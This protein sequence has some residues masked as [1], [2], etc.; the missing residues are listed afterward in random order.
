MRGYNF[1]VVQCLIP[2]RQSPSSSA[3]GQRVHSRLKLHGACE[4]L[5]CCG[6]QLLLAASRT[7]Q[8][9]DANGTQC[10]QTQTQH[11]LPPPPLKT[12]KKGVSEGAGLAPQRPKKQLSCRESCA[13]CHLDCQGTTSR[14]EPEQDTPTP[15][16]PGKAAQ[17]VRRGDARREARQSHAK[18]ACRHCINPTRTQTAVQDLPV[19]D[20]TRQ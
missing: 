3:Y 11:T 13:E 18:A 7:A 5:N 19:P 9:A 10:T 2:T 12:L 1:V 17:D 8:A 6:L 4:Q 20:V 16:L 15:N 14:I